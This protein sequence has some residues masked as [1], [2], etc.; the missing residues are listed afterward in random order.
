MSKYNEL[1]RIYK[2][3]RNDYNPEFIMSGSGCL[4]HNIDEFK[5]FSDVDDDNHNSLEAIF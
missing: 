1:L 4:F 3:K 5:Q 2:A